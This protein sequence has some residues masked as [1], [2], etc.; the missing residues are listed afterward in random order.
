[1]LTENEKYTIIYYN[2]SLMLVHSE[3][4]NYYDMSKWLINYML[5]TQ[6]SKISKILSVVKGDIQYMGIQGEEPNEY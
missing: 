3:F 2:E 6:N 5:E 4:D 1:M